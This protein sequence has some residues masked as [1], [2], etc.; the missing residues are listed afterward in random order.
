MTIKSMVT[1][2][3]LFVILVAALNLPGLAQTGTSI[4]TWDL[5]LPMSDSKEFLGRGTLTARGVGFQI[6]RQ[7]RENIWTGAYFGWHVMNGT[8][9]GTFPLEGEDYKGH[10][11]GKYWSYINVFPVMANVFYQAGTDKGMQ[12]SIGLNAGGYIYEERIEVS[13][14]ALEK[15]RWLF[16]F[17][18]EI[19]IKY[20]VSYEA[21]AYISAKYHFGFKN[22]KTI[23][24]ESTGLSYLTLSIGVAFDHGFF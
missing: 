12:V 19:G 9:E 23:S 13:S 3:T 16:G 11:T 4:L 20:P 18:P 10:G 15:S 14:I 17:A 2:A 5:Q 1:K 21:S 24:G 8:E 7:M 22:S 6:R